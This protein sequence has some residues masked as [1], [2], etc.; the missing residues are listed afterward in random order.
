MF[1]ELERQ[2]GPLHTHPDELVNQRGKERLP[3]RDRH[4]H[5]YR[6]EDEPNKLTVSSMQS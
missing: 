6:A 2:Q 3:M 4:T 1:S 5:T